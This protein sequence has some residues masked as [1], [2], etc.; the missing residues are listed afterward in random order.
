M[1]VLTDTS[2]RLSAVSKRYS[3]KQCSQFS[4]RIGLYLYDPFGGRFFL[5]YEEVIFTFFTLSILNA[6]N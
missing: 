3:T 2:I 5:A 4:L 6:K 1:E